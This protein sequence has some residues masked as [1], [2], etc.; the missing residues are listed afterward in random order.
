M[1]KLPKSIKI[2]NLEWE[3]KYISMKEMNKISDTN[4]M[5]LTQF[6]TTTIYILNEMSYSHKR[7]TLMHEVLHACI[8]IGEG[9]I[10]PNTKDNDAWEHYF[11][12]SLEYTLPEF[13][14]N[15]PDVVKFII[16]NN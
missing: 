14:K 16:G 3:I 7:N 15:N 2:N 1:S 4:P 13:I 5:G 8:Y 10:R 6:G 9:V 11:I 12:N